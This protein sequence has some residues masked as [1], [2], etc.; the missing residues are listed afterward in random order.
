MW[1]DLM[2]LN[3]LQAAQVGSRE[4]YGLKIAIFIALPVLLLE[5]WRFRQLSKG[6]GH[7]DTLK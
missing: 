6:R 5:V 7:K 3:S 2:V 1:P 4:S